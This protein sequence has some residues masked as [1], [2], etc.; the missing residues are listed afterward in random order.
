MEKKE[1]WE[2]S[3]IFA[4][5]AHDK[6]YRKGT[7]LPYIV[8]PI[9]VSF[10]VSTMTD[11][12]EVIAAAALHDVVE[13][14]HYSIEDIRIRF[15]DRVA[16]FVEAES[17]NKRKEMSPEESWKIRKKEFLNRLPD[18]PFEVKI[19][20]LA[21]KLSNMRSTMKE[22]QKVGDAIWDRFNQKNKEEHMWYHNSILTILNEFCE[23]DSWKEYKELCTHVFGLI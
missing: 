1:L 2:R 12:E 11:D 5:K 18:E 6:S 14:T 4:A 23:Y 15:G 10:I 3:L 13:D 20:A 17:E 16:L 8:H 19:I 21:D 9:E 7:K 22:Y